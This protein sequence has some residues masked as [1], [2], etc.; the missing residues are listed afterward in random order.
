MV[1][2][3]VMLAC[4]SQAAG[5]GSRMGLAARIVGRPAPRTCRNRKTQETKRILPSNQCVAKFAAIL[6]SAVRQH[7]PRSFVDEEVADHA[8]E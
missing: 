3:T 2:I 4:E 8:E 5:G 7:Q 6:P 1:V